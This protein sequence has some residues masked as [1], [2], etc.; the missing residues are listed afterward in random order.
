MRGEEQL[1]VII[2]CLS[3][4]ERS[5]RLA[6]T[7][8]DRI[9]LRSGGLSGVEGCCCCSV[10]VE[11]LVGSNVTTP[12]DCAPLIIV[13]LT[14]REEYMIG[15]YRISIIQNTFIYSTFIN[16]AKVSDA[17]GEG[18]C[19]KDQYRFIFFFQTH[20]LLQHIQRSPPPINR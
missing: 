2:F 15:V 17:I 13:T 19:S 4:L 12:P 10:V 3:I 5:V 1:S 7:T 11:Y 9:P 18:E 20:H 16:C 8:R 6:L 14:C